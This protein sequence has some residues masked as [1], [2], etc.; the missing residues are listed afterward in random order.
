MNLRLFSLVIATAIGLGF[1][2][3]AAPARA[4][5]APNASEIARYTGLHIAA[6]LEMAGGK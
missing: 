5:V 2:I 6:M 1:V 4:Q 3:H